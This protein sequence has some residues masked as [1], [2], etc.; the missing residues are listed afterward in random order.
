MSIIT[1]GIDLAKDIFAVQGDNASGKAELIKPRVAR[2]QLLALI[3]KLPPCLI[4]MEACSELL[5][6]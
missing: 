5:A 4:G 3:S 1:V 6:A 2:A